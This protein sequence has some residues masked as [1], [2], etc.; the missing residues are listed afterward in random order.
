MGYDM[1]GYTTLKDSNTQEYNNCVV[2]HVQCPYA[3]QPIF[4]TIIGCDI[5]EFHGR[6]TQK[7]Y[8]EFVSVINKIISAIKNGVTVVQYP[9]N[10]ANCTTNQLIEDFEQLKNGV[11]ERRI[12][13]VS[14]S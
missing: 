12:R 5:K 8:M 2:A 7:N 4:R 3:W 1:V 6:L 11:L 10:L 13:Y 14:I 9:G